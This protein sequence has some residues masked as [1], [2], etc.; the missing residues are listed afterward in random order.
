M[1]QEFGICIE[2]ISHSL[3]KKIQS[4]GMNGLQNS[5]KICLSAKLMFF[6]KLG[7]DAVCEMVD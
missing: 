4:L 7:V 6:K 1:P 2:K 3:S 5:A